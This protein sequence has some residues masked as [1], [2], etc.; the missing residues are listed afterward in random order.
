MRRLV[1]RCNTD[2]ISKPFVLQVKIGFTQF[3]EK[4]WHPFH[5]LGQP[6][7]QCVFSAVSHLAIRLRCMLK[8]LLRSVK[9]K[10]TLQ[11]TLHIHICEIF[12]TKWV[13]QAAVAFSL[14][15]EL[16]DFGFQDTCVD[17]MKNYLWY[18]ENF[19]RHLMKIQ[20]SKKKEN[21]R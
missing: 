18:V 13:F 9:R 4:S 15:S 5:L 6:V 19:Y 3:F 20:C 12:H 21:I 8:L 16:N 10:Q 2:S 11:T 17:L 7:S 1:E 14:S